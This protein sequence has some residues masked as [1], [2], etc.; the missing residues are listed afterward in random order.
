MFARAVGSGASNEL[1]L[2]RTDHVV[3]VGETVLMK[4]HHPSTPLYVAQRATMFNCRSVTQS[5]SDIV[6]RTRDTVL[7]ETADNSEPFQWPDCQ[8]GPL[9]SIVSS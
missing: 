2:G 6:G 4:P 5:P 8:E 3:S 7:G 9:D 1:R